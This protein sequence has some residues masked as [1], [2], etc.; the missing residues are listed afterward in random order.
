M[1]PLETNCYI[2]YSGKMAVVIDP[3]GQ[4]DEL[5]DLAN[6]EG[7]Q[8]THILLTHLHFDHT[9]GVRALA[10]GTGAKT[11]ASEKDRFMLQSEMGLG[12]MWGMPSVPKYDFAGIEPGDLKLECGMCKVLETPGHSPGGLSFYFDE[13]QAVFSGD[14]L[15]YRSIGR[16]DLPGGNQNTLLRSIREQLY[17]LPDETAVYPGHGL[18]SFIGDEKLNNPY[19]SDF[20][21]V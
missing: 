11:L 14:S 9:Y 6:H 2:V 19:S 10:E 5:L 15:F 4:A 16:T 17:S 21:M 18:S 12:G 3:G 7:L 1:G 8:I 13:I 20:I